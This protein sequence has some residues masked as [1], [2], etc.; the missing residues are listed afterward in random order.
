MKSDRLMVSSCH[1]GGCQID[2]PLQR[3]PDMPKISVFSCF[4]R[5]PAT[6]GNPISFRSPP[7]RGLPKW[8]HFG[9][10][11]HLQKVPLIRNHPPIL[12]N[13][14]LKYARNY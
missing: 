14:A 10:P 5:N 8:L 4:S 11:G 2:L 1:I 3:L 6:V 13:I 12:A 7:L 9:L